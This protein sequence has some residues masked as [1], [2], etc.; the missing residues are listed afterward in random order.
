MPLNI[1]VRINEIH[2]GIFQLAANSLLFYKGSK[3][4]HELVQL[5]SSEKPTENETKLKLS[6]FSGRAAFRAVTISFVL[7]V[8]NQLCG[9]YVLLGYS[10]KVFED[11]G[12][13]LSPIEASIWICVVQLVASIITIYL[14]DRAGRKILFISSSVGAGIGLIGLGM[15]AVHKDNLQDHNWI[16]VFTVALI[17]FIASLGLLALPF[18]I[19]M[20]LLPPK[21][22]V[23]DH[24]MRPQRN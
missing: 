20:D 10:T 14:V 1:Y 21:V 16:P 11:A 19:S 5:T 7:I 9:C 22:R 18:T 23:A 3:Y 12:S 17:T 24:Q 2:C 13:N 8:L 6:D 15:H 4:I